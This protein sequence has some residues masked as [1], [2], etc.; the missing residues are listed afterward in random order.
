MSPN[1]IDQKI[2]VARRRKEA[3]QREADE[4]SRELGECFAEV[5][6][7]DLDLKAHAR[8]AN[9]SRT[10]AYALAKKFAP[11]KGEASDHRQRHR[12]RRDP[13]PFPPVEAGTT[14]AAVAES[15]T[16]IPDHDCMENAVPYVSDGP[17][18]HGWECGICGT[19]L[20][21]G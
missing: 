4:G 11:V 10:T 20:Q 21:A 1:D 19:F 3:G 8:L 18:G 6:R 7:Q 13:D 9:I 15:D 14:A 12:D 16:P 17:L 5:I 2:G